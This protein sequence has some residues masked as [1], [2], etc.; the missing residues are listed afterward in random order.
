MRDFLKYT[1]ASLTGSILF[2]LLLVGFITVSSLGVISALLASL[3]S[4]GRLTAVEQN[5]VLVYDLSIQITDSEDV[6]SPRESFLQLQLG[7][8]RNQ[9]TLRDA[10]VAIQSAAQ[11]DRIVALYLE[12]STA[13]VGAGGAALAE[14]RRALEQF[15]E[16][17]KPII[18]YDVTWDEQEYYLASAANT[19]AI[20]P[21]GQ[22]EMNG[23][24][25]Q[26]M[27]QAE[28]LEKLG[29]GVQVTR[30]GKYKSAVEPLIRNSMSPEER[31]QTR[32]ILDDLW[33][34]VLETASGYRSL[35]PQ[36]LQAIADGSGLLFSQEAQTQGLV[37]T[38][39]H[40]DELVTDFREL[41]GEGENK[42][43]EES[44]RQIS[45]KKYAKTAQDQLAE[46]ASNHQI[47]LVYAEG[48]IVSGNGEGLGL[49]IAGDRLAKQLRQ[50]RYDE[51]VKAIVLRVNS[52]GGSATAAETILR[53]VKLA[54]QEKPVIVSMGNLAASGGYWISAFADQIFAEPTTITGSI[55]VFGAYINLQD[56]GDKVGINWDVVKTADTADIFSSTRPKTDRE[57]EILQQ[58]VDKIYAEFLQR[59]AEG[60]DLPLEKVAEIA[61]GRVW[62]GTAARELG[63]VDELGG[64][65]EAIQAA[66]QAAQLEDDW[67]LKEYPKVEGWQ[68]LLEQLSEQRKNFRIDPLTAQFEQFKAEIELLKTLNDPQHAYARIPFT[69]EV[70]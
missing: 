24:F 53:E 1:L 10:L 64:L 18:A 12:G 42:A 21:L 20:N 14:L 61:Q 63:L 17:G 26:V 62:S 45:L 5:S 19:V 36:Q 48:A 2:F 60:R 7:G 27:Y 58:A 8:V 9:M 34:N 11:D 35:Q 55:G 56:L 37:D 65:E 51:A 68:R 41:T 50:L 31:E 44:F 23:L 16:S 38:V 52:P 32:R 29:V 39:A 67:Q 15:R 47:A 54:Q 22:Q 13:S 70:K 30:V 33:N 28:A 40:F 57:L 4:R 43:T 49:V 3:S 66:A 25:S 69:I 59:V 6:L 46:R